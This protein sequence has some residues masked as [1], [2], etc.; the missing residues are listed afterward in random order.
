MHAWLELPAH[1]RSAALIQAAEAAGIGLAG[2][3]LFAAGHFPSPQ[4]VRLS[5]SHPL[6]N[7]ALD[8]ALTTLCQLLESPGPTQNFM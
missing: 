3:E 4:A 2:A 8:Q 7:Q 1:W 6:D 5:I